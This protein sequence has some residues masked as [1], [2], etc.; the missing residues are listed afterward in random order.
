VAIDPAVPAFVDLAAQWSATLGPFKIVH[1]RSIPIETQK[2]Y[3]EALMSL[4]DP[5]R[6]FPNYGGTWRLPL[7]SSGIAFVD[8]A[9]V[10]QVQVADLLAGAALATLEAK[11]TRKIYGFTKKLLATRIAEL[12]YSQV[13][14]TLAIT[15]EEL[16]AD[17]RP[18]SASLNYMMEVARRGRERQAQGQAK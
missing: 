12:S 4:S 2:E 8:S 6:E 9:S 15:P 7:L 18:G 17:E 16:H 5:G 11:L 14:P 1:D 3:L 10:P 13:W